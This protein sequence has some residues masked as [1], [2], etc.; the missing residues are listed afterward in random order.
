MR[1]DLLAFLRCQGNEGKPVPG[2]CACSVL[3]REGGYPEVTGTP[4]MSPRASSV[5]DLSMVQFT[6]KDMSHRID[7]MWSPSRSKPLPGRLTHF[8]EAWPRHWIILI[9]K[10]T[11]Q[12]VQGISRTQ[13]TPTPIPATGVSGCSRLTRNDL[14]SVELAAVWQREVVRH[15]PS[16]SP[17]SKLH[18]VTARP[19][20]GTQWPGTWEKLSSYSA[21]EGAPSPHSPLQ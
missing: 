14:I 13:P 6:S 17:C 12:I 5:Q 18:R 19:C 7:G 20:H 1:A 16:W 11:P 4:E 9:P 15:A 21:G 8:C 3:A 10:S 2:F